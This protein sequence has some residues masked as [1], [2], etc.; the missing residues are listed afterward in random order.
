MKNLYYTFRLK[1]HTIPKH[2][3]ALHNTPTRKET[4]CINLYHEKK[5]LSQLS[6]Y[7]G[8]REERIEAA[9]AEA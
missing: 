5:N 6:T 3:E 7:L 9:V 1:P 2:P 4:I 8:K